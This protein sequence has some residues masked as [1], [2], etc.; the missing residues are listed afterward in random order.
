M[1]NNQHRYLNIFFSSYRHHSLAKEPTF[2]VTLLYAWCIVTM[3]KGGRTVRLETKSAV[4]QSVR[5]W[6][7]QMSNA[8]SNQ[9]IIMRDKTVHGREQETVREGMFLR[10]IMWSQ[11][12]RWLESNMCWYMPRRKLQLGMFSKP[13][14]PHTNSPYWP[15]YISL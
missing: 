1:V 11:I 7:T 6:T 13:Q 5:S 4:L 10:D 2:Q 9:K 8:Q 3:D 15:Q 12:T 14:C